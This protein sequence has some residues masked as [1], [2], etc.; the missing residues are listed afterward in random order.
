MKKPMFF[1]DGHQQALDRLNEEKFTPIVQLQDT[2]ITEGHFQDLVDWGYADIEVKVDPVTKQKT[3]S[4][5]K[6]GHRGKGK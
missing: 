3:Y 1:N 5:K 4:Y 2:A 6:K